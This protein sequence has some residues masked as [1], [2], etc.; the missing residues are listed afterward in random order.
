FQLDAPAMRE[1]LDGASVCFLARPNNPTSS[2]FEKATIEGLV[3]DFPSTIFVLDEAYAAYLGGERALASIWRPDGPENLVLMTTLSKIGRAALRLGHCIAP[4]MLALALNKV[5]HPYNISATSLVL[6]EAALTEFGEV[7]SAM[8]SRAI[9]HR[10]ALVEL[11]QQIPRVRVYP[12][13]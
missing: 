2:L 9:A 12:A 5:R 10:D 1:A 3:R 8:I 13:T 7:Q 11:V 4:P 6:A